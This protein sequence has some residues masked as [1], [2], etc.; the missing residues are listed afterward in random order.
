MNEGPSGWPL[1]VAVIAVVAGA[2]VV[3]AL[4]LQAIT[5]ALW[6]TGGVC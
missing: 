5:E 6:S 4:F 3:V 1:T 2:I